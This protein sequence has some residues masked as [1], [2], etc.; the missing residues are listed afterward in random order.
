[1]ADYID[2]NREGR[3]IGRFSPMAYMPGGVTDLMAAT[4]FI[5]ILSLA[6]PLTLLQIYDRILPNS[7]EGTLMLLISGVAVALMLEA[8]LR[9]GRTYVSGWM[10]A[11]FEHMAGCGALNRMLT[12]NIVDYEKTGSGVHMERLA[13]LQVLKD[14][15]AGQAI[16]ALCDLP[17]AILFLAMITYLAG[18]LVFVPIVLVTAFAITAW[19]IGRKLRD[20]LESRTIA[21]DRRF[22]FIIEVLG[23]IH[24]LKG[25]GMEEQMLR[26]YERLQETCADADH[27]VAL[28]SSK[29]MNA[30]S[31]YSQLTMFLVVGIGSTLVIDGLLTVGGLAACTML[32]GRSMQPLQKAVGIWTRFQAIQLAR[33]RVRDIFELMPETREG[34]PTLPEIDGQLEMRN[35]TFSYGKNKDGE[36]LPN[37]TEGLSL[38][39]KPGETIGICGGNA[40]GKTSLLFLMQGVLKPDVGQVFVDGLDIDDF[41]TSSV[42][43]QVAYLPQ[44]GALFN[45]TI[46][47]NITMWRPELGQRALDVARMMGLDDAIVHMPFG[48]ETVVGDGAGESM[49]R[50]IKQRI[51]I[52]RALVDRPKILLFDEANAAM[53]AKAD[54]VLRDFLEQVKGKVTLILVTHRPSVLNLSERV[55]DFKDGKLIERIKEEPKKVPVKSRCADSDKVPAQRTMKMVL[56]PSGKGA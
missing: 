19:W 20:A 23:G 33:K 42:R 21:D 8:V 4:L 25:L 55:Y 56:K 9:I 13:A 1:M 15:Y 44:A 2:N 17:F 52:A 39:V 5:N 34:L 29:A 46:L 51:A 7:A 12:S 43:R 24:T 41:E 31:L 54:G 27:K 35:I 6:L 49:P 11:R 32:A 45:G 28:N 10:G 53:D 36:Q 40:V 37:I 30:G 47:E 38:I 18:Y 14:F 48:Y 16:I 26:R 50:G 22:N 3:L